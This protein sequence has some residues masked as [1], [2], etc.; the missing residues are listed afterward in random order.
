M[1]RAARTAG[2]SDRLG[3][4]QVARVVKGVSNITA[5]IRTGERAGCAGHSI[6]NSVTEMSHAIG[7]I[8]GRIVLSKTADE[9]LA[10]TS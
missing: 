10:L 2:E 5:Q 6:A 8:S 9:L 3:I 7:E 4:G 1:P